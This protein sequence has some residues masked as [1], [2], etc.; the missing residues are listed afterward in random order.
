MDGAQQYPAEVSR[1]FD[2]WNACDPAQ[3]VAAITPAGGY[4]DPTVSNPPLSGPSLEEHARAWFLAFPDL[5]FDVTSTARFA[6]AHN[7]AGYVVHWLAQGTHAGRLQGLPA[8]HGSLALRGVDIITIDDGASILAV[9][10]HF[11]RQT[12]AEQLGFQVIVQP[13]SDAIWQLGYAWR[14]TAGSTANPGA[15]SMTWTTARSPE[16]A[17]Q[18]EEIGTLFGAELTEAPGFIS[19]IAGGIG[20]RL[21]TIAAWENEDAIR[22]A[23]RNKLHTGGVQLFHNEDFLG[24]FGS[25][26][27]T[28]RRVGAVWVRC[29]SCARLVQESN[30]DDANC[31]CG[32]P[33]SGPRERW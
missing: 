33:L 29:T 17:E 30:D 16:E 5:R 21:F 22:S 7:P 3:I 15:I 26:I 25:G 1:Y 27:F 8:M 14:A 18:L 6:G 19:V 32:Q 2:A 10:R 24:S 12:M 11:D 13:A 9:E 23:L 4:A 20:N 31:T 28:A